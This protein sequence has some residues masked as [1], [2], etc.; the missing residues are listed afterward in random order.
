MNSAHNERQLLTVEG[1]EKLLGRG[2]GQKITL[3]RGGAVT[4][5][6]DQL[7]SR[8]LPCQE[9]CYFSTHTHL[10]SGCDFSLGDYRTD[11]DWTRSRANRKW[12]AQDPFTCACTPLCSL[13]RTWYCSLE[14]SCWAPLTLTLAEVRRGSGDE[15]RLETQAGEPKT[16]FW[17]N[18]TMML[19]LDYR[20]MDTLSSCWTM[21]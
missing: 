9:T 6:N 5:V 13:V 7:A 15:K 17:G 10:L 2:K 12:A 16:I 20:S 8:F 18:L 11:L 3:C 19:S 14:G 1:R 4:M 21:K